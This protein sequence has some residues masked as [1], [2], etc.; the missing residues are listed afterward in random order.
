MTKRKFVI[1]DIACVAGDVNQGKSVKKKRGGNWEG[2]K[3]TIAVVTSVI[4]WHVSLHCFCAYLH[5]KL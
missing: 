2:R 1:V 3:G 4:R 5:T